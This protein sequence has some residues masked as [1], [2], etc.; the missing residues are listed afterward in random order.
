MNHAPEPPETGGDDLLAGLLD[1]LDHDRPDADRQL[2]TRAYQVA[3]YW[4]EGELRRSGDPYI[5]HPV[6]VAAILARNGADDQTLC[7]A[8]LH[9]VVEDS[10]CTVDALRDEL[11]AEIAGLV[12]GLMTFDAMTGDQVAAAVVTGDAAAL[13]ADRRII[14]IKLADR[15]HN[16]QTIQHLPSAKQ[17]QKSQQTLDV[18]VPVARALRIDPIGSDLESLAATV[19]R[20]LQ[21]PSTASGRLLA[22]TAVLLPPAT[23]ARWREEW[24]AELHE[25]STRRA[26]LRF[27]AQILRGIG[28]LAVTLYGA[29]M[30]PG[31]VRRAGLAA[32][33]LASGLVV[34]GWRA[35]TAAVLGLLALAGVLAWVL[36]SDDRT[37]RL[38]R[39]IRAFGSRAR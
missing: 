21:P 30:S 7:A 28:Q 9:D 11:G 38:V 29:D 22:A 18:L 17:V 31:W 14:M 25:L 4:H 26:R 19:L 1:V 12:D 6:A 34:S 3:A 13:A 35:V 24:L 27:A 23:R 32:A 20:R 10:A 36:A 2:I 39:V 16:M 37:R 33:G 15:L 8:L 5:T